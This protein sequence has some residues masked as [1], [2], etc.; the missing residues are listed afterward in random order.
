MEFFTTPM[1]NS[2]QYIKCASLKCCM[3]QCTFKDN[4]QRKRKH[5]GK[6]NTKVWKIFVMKISGSLTK[7]C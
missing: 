5:K 7:P 2:V 1:I 6:E 3:Q 4:Q